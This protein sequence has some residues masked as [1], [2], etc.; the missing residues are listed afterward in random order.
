MQI[1]SDDNARRWCCSAKEVMC[2]NLQRKPRAKRHEHTVSV[3]VDGS[4]C[5][6]AMVIQSFHIRIFSD[7]GQARQVQPRGALPML[8]VVTIV[9]DGS[10]R[11]TTEAV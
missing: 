9:L 5:G 4:G 1:E 3:V 8:M 11:S 7:G 10:K 2:R 6:K